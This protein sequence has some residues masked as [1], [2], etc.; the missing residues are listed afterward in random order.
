[1]TMSW[2]G[3]VI[4]FY[5]KVI[6]LQFLDS[7]EIKISMDISPIFRIIPTNGNP[8][9]RGVNIFY[10][11]SHCAMAYFSK[12]LW[13]SS[14]ALFHLPLIECVLTFLMETKPTLT[15]TPCALEIIDFTHTLSPVPREQRV[16]RSGKSGHYVSL[17]TVQAWVCDSEGTNNNRARRL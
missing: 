14:A 9:S 5:Y 15:P 16:V 17:P 13:F 7:T 3:Y 6:R 11:S 10:D 8:V 1:M 4:L 12:H 2:V